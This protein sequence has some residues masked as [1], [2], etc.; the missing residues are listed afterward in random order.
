M[1][2][3]GNKE[4]SVKKIQTQIPEKNRGSKEAKQGR[5]GKRIVFLFAS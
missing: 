3:P 4:P 2:V 5:K 1:E